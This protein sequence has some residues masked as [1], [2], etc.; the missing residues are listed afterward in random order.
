MEMNFETSRIG[1]IDL[2]TWV[3]GKSNP[4]DEDWSVVIERV[5]QLLRERG[6]STQGFRTVVTT[7]GGGP[8]TT[9]RAKLF[10]DVYGSK[11]VKVSVFNQAFDNPLLRGVVTAAMWLNPGVKPFKISEWKKGLQHIDLQDS[12]AQVSALLEKM[13]QKMPTAALSSLQKA[14]RGSEAKAS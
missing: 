9:Q 13:A 3:H 4:S 7:E 6:G 8:T 10:R 11:P 12:V 1:E 2:L 5:R 14:I